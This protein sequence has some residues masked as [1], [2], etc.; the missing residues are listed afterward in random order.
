MSASYVYVVTN[1]HGV[2]LSLH[3]SVS[4]AKFKWRSA[5]HPWECLTP[6]KVWMREGDRREYYIER[7][8]VTS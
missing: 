8:G 5:D 2:I 7:Y 4:G 3:R 6:R 1:D